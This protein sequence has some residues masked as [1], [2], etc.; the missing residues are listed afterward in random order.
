MPGELLN[1]STQ[2]WTQVAPV[3]E[4]RTYHSVA[5]LL[6]DATVLAGGGG[7]CGIGCLQNH[8]TAQVWSPPY[9]FNP[10]GSAARRPVIQ[11]CTP[12]LLKPGARFTIHMA[13][14]YG[15]SEGDFTFALIR[16]GTSTHTVNTD[17]RRIPL[18]ATAKRGPGL[19]YSLILPVDPGVLVPGVYMLFAMNRAGVPSISKQLKI[20]AL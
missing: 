3:A 16:Y 8:F 7:L 14:A 9:L 18:K 2:S 12:G 15:A 20:Q 5:L 13:R 17:Q 19:E 4:A 10:D 6:P 1:P 11:D